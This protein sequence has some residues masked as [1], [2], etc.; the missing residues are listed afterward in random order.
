MDHSCAIWLPGRVNGRRPPNALETIQADRRSVKD[1]TRRD[2][3]KR[4]LREASCSKGC[5]QSPEPA[6]TRAG[7][8]VSPVP[9][10]VPRPLA[11]P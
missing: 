3:I 7:T 8:G 1:N 5:S 10:F 11:V 2:C 6:A 9:I 4:L